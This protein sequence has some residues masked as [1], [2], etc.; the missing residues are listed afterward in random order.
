MDLSRPDSFHSPLPPS[1]ALGQTPLVRLPDK[2]N[3]DK[4]HVRG[5][6]LQLNLFFQF[7]TL[8][9]GND[10]LKIAMV[11]SLLSGDALNWVAPYLERPEQHANVLSNFSEF[12]ALLMN[13]FGQKDRA[14]LAAREL[15]QLRQGTHSAAWYSSEFRRIAA[16]LEWADQPLIHF[17]YSGLSSRVKD[18]LVFQD[19]PNSLEELI[20]LSI[21]A[22]NRI[23]ERR[24]SNFN[25]H[26]PHLPFRAPR[27]DSTPQKDD[28]MDVDKS[29]KRGRLTEV[30]RAHRRK[31]NLCMYCG[32]A[33]HLVKDCPLSRKTSRNNNMET[34]NTDDSKK[35]QDQ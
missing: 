7:N 13:T 27:H 21:K 3:G 4:S 32:S 11:A 18:L 16:D 5:F 29:K 2:F 25:R 6:M 24:A 28:P 19:M 26:H 20:N 31:N 15:E 1:S 17:F 10:A 14:H 23:E 33:T 22:D 35:E 34:S 30:E 12:K 8:F 9:E